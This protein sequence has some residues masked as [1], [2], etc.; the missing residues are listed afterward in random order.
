MSTFQADFSIGPTAPEPV[1]ASFT[2]DDQRIVAA[3]ST[4]KKELILFQ[5]LITLERELK[6][7]K[8]ESIKPHQNNI[9][10]LLLKYI[11]SANPKPSRPI[12]RAVARCFVALYTYGDTRTLFDTM[13]TALAIVNRKTEELTSKLSA[14]YCIGSLSEA[15]GDKILSL[16]PEMTASFIKILKSCKDSDIPMK[17]EITIALKRALTCAGRGAN[18]A[19]V[20]DLVRLARLG[21][22]DKASIIRSSSIE[23]LQALYQHTS[24]LPCLKIEE[25]DALLSFVLKAAEQSSYTV[26]RA[27]ASFIA[28]IFVRSQSPPPAIKKKGVTEPVILDKILR[29]DQLFQLFSMQ[30]QKPAHAS[31]EIRIAIVESLA[32]TFIQLGVKFVETNYS[33]ILSSVPEMIWNPRATS[34]RNESLVAREFCDYI[35]RDVLGKMLS[36]S[37]EV[38]AVREIVSI[39]KRTVSAQPSSGIKPGAATLTEA[40]NDHTTI[41]V[42]NELSALHLELGS[43]SSV[44]QDVVMECLVELLPHPTPGVNLALAWCLRSVCDA[45]P[46][47]LPKLIQRLVGLLQKHAP[48]LTSDRADLLDKYVGYANILAAVISVIPART[49]YVSFESAFLVFGFSTQLLKTSA[50]IKDPKLATVHVK[51]AWTLIGSLMCLGPQFVG[52]HLSQLLLIWKNVFPKINSSGKTDVEWEFHLTV[53]DS[54]LAA[55]HSFILYNGSLASADVAKRVIVCLSNALVFVTSLPANVSHVTPTGPTLPGAAPQISHKIVEK[56]QLVRKRIF[57]CYLALGSPALYENNYGILVR[58]VMDTF[59]PEVEKQ[60]PTTP[61]QGQTHSLVSF[62]GVVGTGS[63]AHSGST[64]MSDDL[65]IVTSLARGYSNCVASAAAAED[66]GIAKALLVETDVKKVEDQLDG[67]LLGTLAYDPHTL[68]LHHGLV[69]FEHPAVG[70]QDPGLMRLWSEQPRPMPANIAVVD[71]AIELFA[72]IFPHQSPQT[73]DASLESLLKICKLPVGKVSMARKVSLQ[74]NISTAIIGFLRYLS[75]RKTSAPSPRAQSLVVELVDDMLVS[76]DPVLRFAASEVLGRLARAVGTP[77]FINPLMQS[78]IDRVVNVREPDSRCGAA[79][80]LGSIHSYV[81]GMTG[82]SHLKNIVG[83]LHSLASDPH[84]LVHTWA[85]HALWLT[86]ESAGLMFANY[87]NPTL[88]LIAKLYMS[89]T[90]EPSAVQANGAGGDSNCDVYPGFG[91]LLHALVGV[92]GPEFQC[93]PKVRELC[94]ALYEEL[95]NESD[96]FVVVQAIRCIQNFILFAPTH[97]NIQQLVPFLQLQLS[98]SLESQAFLIRHASITCLYQLTQRD[99]G[100]VLEAAINNQLEEQ[101]FGLLDTETDVMTQEEVKDILKHLL[102]HVAPNHPSR[103]LEICKNIL[104]K[105]GTSGSTAANDATPKN[106]MERRDDDDDDRLEGDQDGVGPATGSTAKSAAVRAGPAIAA[107]VVVLLPR[108]RTQT[109]AFSC[110]RLTLSVVVSTQMVEHVDLA[111]ARRKREQLAGSSGNISDST[112]YVVFKLQELIRMAFTAATAVVDELRIE[113]LRLLDD[114]LEKFQTAMDP[115]YEGH[116]LLEQYQAQISSSLTPAFAA[117]SSPEVLSIA[118][119]VS[120]AYVGSGINQD[121]STLSRILKLLATSLDKCTATPPPEYENFPHAF[122]M[123]KLSI[124]VA[125]A[126][127]Y[128]ASLEKSYLQSVVKPNL[129]RLGQLWVSILKDYAQFKIERETV[130]Y[131]GQPG[132]SSIDIYMAA[133][134]EVI[135]PFYSGSWV[136]VL[137]ALSNLAHDEVEVFIKSVSD[138]ADAATPSTEQQETSP[139]TVLKDTFSILFGLCIE[140]ISNSGTVGLGLSGIPG[141]QSGGNANA[142]EEKQRSIA[143]AL[144]ICLSSIHKLARPKIF[145]VHIF[146]KGIFTDLVNVLDR[147]LQSEDAPMQLIVAQIIAQIAADFDE[148]YLSGEASRAAR[149]ISTSAEIKIS[150]PLPPVPVSKVY[151]LWKLLVSALAYHVPTLSNNPTAEVTSNRPLSPVTIQLV[152]LALDTLARLLSPH[153][154]EGYGHQLF[155]TFMTV[156]LGILT[157]EKFSKDIHPKTLVAMKVCTEGLETHLPEA[158]KPIVASVVQSS[159]RNILDMVSAKSDDKSESASEAKTL[160][161][162]AIVLITG[163]PVLSYNPTLQPDIVARIMDLLDSSDASVALTG[164]QCTKSLILLVNKADPMAS[165][166]GAAYTRLL[167]PRLVNKLYEIQQQQQHQSTN[168]ASEQSQT[169]VHEMV[170]VL[171]WIYDVANTDTKKL[172]TLAMIVPIL[173]GLLEET[174]EPTALHRVA[175]TSLLELATKSPAHFKPIIGALPPDDRGSLE[176]ALVSAIQARDQESAYGGRQAQSSGGL[177]Q[178]AAAPKIQLKNFGAF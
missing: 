156:A 161:L 100:A 146:D 153:I 106:S 145:G 134:R 175:S 38:V 149:D 120:A 78:L 86:I 21:I 166:V 113:G 168:D 1:P 132:D 160:V 43:A 79:L 27:I 31:R 102:R 152:C 141:T 118:C 93:S 143:L 112:D 33:L 103:W 41:C 98:G 3:D 95:K 2:F 6:G 75:A 133:R 69:D 131:P 137:Q 107:I 157:V 42:L 37:G 48:T 36:E 178:R 117:E 26:R 23:L 94:F 60:P 126:K 114:I 64:Q 127:L 163:C 14:I 125:W 72:S 162:A 173:I 91:R 105:T 148:T 11:T 68:Y 85:L 97:V 88:S 19:T 164:L 29:V 87:V 77:S 55:L 62:T 174:P 17:A 12:R 159:I 20:K 130:S 158:S 71:A 56:E 116:A 84:P 9:E 15:F 7:C 80:A 111:T 109:F 169:V 44:T 177:S 96:P 124:L 171:V 49:L 8:K 45:L 73:Q 147:V 54:A 101:L 61:S 58:V 63:N 155:P 53:K 74:I 25:Y 121:L 135:L 90:H 140:S 13:V 59:A 172:S 144:E 57:Q 22:G 176:K 40:P 123:L 138:N 128:N 142:L 50:S 51:V 104:S 151:H 150:A 115:D 34:A 76:P 99:P 35:F 30:F 122:T 4:D 39:L 46:Q 32:S 66:R 83:I 139:E 108:W 28:S 170:K 136:L 154:I 119:R 70:R 67:R 129:P 89:E 92:L 10:K 5:W 82:S 165:A 81:G 24:Q 110:L 47:Q 167:V 16:Y 18:E 65:Q 52:A